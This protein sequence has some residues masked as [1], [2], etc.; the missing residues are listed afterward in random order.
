MG[1]KT[2]N[3]VMNQPLEISSKTIRKVGKILVAARESKGIN[4][5]SFSKKM[6]KAQSFISK[7]ENNVECPS[8]ITVVRYLDKLGLKLIVAEK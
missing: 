4:Q 7:V 8:L 5:F 3:S 6:K 1:Y 2:T